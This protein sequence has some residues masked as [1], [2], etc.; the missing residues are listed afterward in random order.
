MS[1]LQLPRQMLFLPEL[2]PHFVL[3]VQDVFGWSIR[4][5]SSGRVVL[6]FGSDLGRPIEDLLQSARDRGGVVVDAPSVSLHNQRFWKR[7]TDELGARLLRT[8]PS[9][10]S[11][12]RSL[13]E[14]ELLRRAASSPPVEASRLLAGPSSADWVTWNALHLLVREWPDGAWWKRLTAQVAS[15]NPVCN[16]LPLGTVPEISFWRTTGP[17]AG[18]K[19]REEPARVDL[20]FGSPSYLIY[21]ES[22]IKQDIPL[23]M[24]GN[25]RRNRLVRL[26]DCLLEEAGE[27][28]CAL[29]IFARDVDDRRQY[30]QLT[31]LYRASPE[32]FAAELKHHPAEALYNLAGRLTVVRWRDLL[33]PALQRRAGDD[34]VVAQVRSALRRRLQAA[35]A[36]AAAAAAR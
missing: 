31:N 5:Y 15:S 14:G 17:S 16:S 27:R 4:D 10:Q 30:V 21:I 1:A 24:P 26:A 23:S 3:V 13:G 7:L 33:G 18:F 19:Q 32:M 2:A 11:E 6:R 29:W 22:K 9:T 35:A 20:T 12:F 8:Q 28:P 25:K 34:A 36:V